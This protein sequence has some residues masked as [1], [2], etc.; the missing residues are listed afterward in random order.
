MKEYNENKSDP[1]ILDNENDKKENLI[2]NMPADINNNLSNKGISETITSLKNENDKKP[3]YLR[4]QTEE[5]KIALLSEKEGLKRILRVIQDDLSLEE[6]TLEETYEPFLNNEDM[7][8]RIIKYGTGR[9]SLIFM[10]YI[11]SP[12]FGVINLI[13]VFENL[14]MMKILLQV[15]QNAFIAF[16]NSWFKKAENIDRY[17]IYDFNMNYNYYYMFFED[18]KKDSFDFNLM[19]FTAFIGDLLLQSRG[20]RVSTFVFALINAGSFFLILSFSFF[21]YDLDYNTYSFFRILY[22]LLAY[23]SLLIG[24]GASA[25]LSQ[26]IIIDSN[27]KYNDYVKLMNEETL[28]LIEE[29]R[30]EKEAERIKKGEQKLKMI[31]EIITFKNEDMKEESENK[32]IL[33]EIEGEKNIQINVIKDSHE[34]ENNFP[35]KNTKS[36][37]ISFSKTEKIFFTGNNEVNDNKNKDNNL[38]SFQD[39]KKNIDEVNR[40]K[41]M[42]GRAK[43]ILVTKNDKMKDNFTNRMKEKEKRK[44]QREE[45]KANV[46]KKNKFDSFFMVC[47]TTIIGY[48]IKYLINIVIAEKNLK[49]EN[50]MYLTNCGT[51]TDCFQN[52]IMDKNLTKSDINLFN[53]IIENLYIDG[54]KSFI[55]IIIIYAGC[56]ISSILLYSFFI[57]IFEKEKKKE[58]EKNLKNS[59]RVCEICGY[60]IYSQN[61]ILNQNP[62]FCQ[63]CKLLC[64]TFSNCLNMALCSIYECHCCDEEENE[65][66]NTENNKN[67]NSNKLDDNNINKKNSDSNKNNNKI[68]KNEKVKNK[69]NDKYDEEKEDRSCCNS[70]CEYKESDYRKNQQF[71][72]YCYQAQRKSYWFNK[73]L[74]ND[75]QK[76][77]VPFMIEYF[78]LEILI[79]AFEQ[80]YFFRFENN[81]NSNSNA[82]KT[83]ITNIIYTDNNK[84]HN[85]TNNN[86]S[87]NFFIN[88]FYNFLIFI[89]SFFLFFY[90]T[91]SFHKIIN[92]TYEPEKK[93]MEEGGFQNLRNL[94]LG[95]LGGTHGVLLFDGLFSL[96]FSSLYLSDSDN[97]IFENNNFVLVPILIN[98]FYYF[99]LIFYCLSYSEEKRKFELISSST[100]ISVY[101]FIINTIIS[102]IRTYIPLKVLYII[103]LIFACCFP[104]ICILLI[105]IYLFCIF[106]NPETSCSRKL[107]F[108]CFISS[109]ICCFGGFWMTGDFYNRLNYSTSEEDFDCSCDCFCDCCYCWIDCLDYIY[110]KCGCKDICPRVMCKCCNCCVCYDCGGCCDCFYC[111]GDECACEFF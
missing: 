32:N 52:I 94:S 17:S 107:T 44:Q 37:E 76:K 9:C 45:A 28:E 51:D 3:I 1:P 2:C 5:E 96:V 85:Y 24:A 22:L 73:F 103:Q 7:T 27:Y 19:V 42:L 69:N 40:R 79:C 26:Q 12:L 13:A 63:C 18:A 53:K 60:I 105:L 99:T 93:N 83:S 100:L 35:L 77:L 104:C 39:I 87:N 92:F 57:C 68:G 43:T 86:D 110:D 78:F 16:Y 88:D 50:Y 47:L 97:D 14:L 82:N 75:I 49:I 80:Q 41:V 10:F 29:R 55:I 64:E 81:D 66:D 62:P 108:L 23:I 11:V 89:L 8:K 61:I 33:N 56:I 101:L 15:L 6:D 21:N 91:L 106:I 90:L 31:N 30:K 84:T 72:C 36:E 38:K 58:N 54:E 20:F 34:E 67:D 65:D 48:F 74:T 102:L 25:L 109:F 46:K 95:I 111:C 98:K 59:Y 71:F 70:C 4:K